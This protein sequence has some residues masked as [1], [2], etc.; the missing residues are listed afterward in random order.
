MSA[1]CQ[2]CPRLQADLLGLAAAVR[3]TL[4]L[5]TDETDKPTQSRAKTLLTVESRLEIALDNVG[6]G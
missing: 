6:R 3:A 2:R 4:Q 1:D 5:V